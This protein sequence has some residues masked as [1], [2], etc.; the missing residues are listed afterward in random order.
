MGGGERAERLFG[1]S[2]EGYVLSFGANLETTPTRAAVAQTI[3]ARDRRQ[4]RLL[5]IGVDGRKGE[6]VAMAVTRHL[7]RMG[8]PAHL[9]VIGC[10]PQLENE[11]EG[12]QF[13]TRLG[14]LKKN[15][16]G[17]ARIQEEFARSHFLIVPSIAECFGIVYCEA[18][19]FGVPSIA[20]NVG[21]VASA[22]RNGRNGRR[23][24]L[25]RFPGTDRGMDCLR[26]PRF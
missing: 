10:D 11:D 19:S 13:V 6:P 2:G 18:S 5:F 3:D 17:Q 9:T 26:V 8:I 7:N 25:R 22:V 4:V 16:A 1:I 23:F 14:F 21:G 20:R 12:R 24:E 15:A